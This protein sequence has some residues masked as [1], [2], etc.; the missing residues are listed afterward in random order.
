MTADA[1]KGLPEGRVLLASALRRL[2]CHRRTTALIRPPHGGGRVLPSEV[3]PINF[4]DY[5]AV[6]L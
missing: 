2:R 1:A 5:I 6:Q 3:L 4:S